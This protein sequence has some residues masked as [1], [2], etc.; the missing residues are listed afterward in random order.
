MGDP[1]L[2]NGG[3]VGIKN[4]KTLNKL[5]WKFGRG[6]LPFKPLLWFRVF[7]LENPCLVASAW[8]ARV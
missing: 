1:K 7:F 2:A 6:L 5:F 3:L 8:G 4:Y